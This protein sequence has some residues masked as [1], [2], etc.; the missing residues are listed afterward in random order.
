MMNYVLITG[1]S[2]G[3]GTIVVN[4]FLCAGLK[5]IIFDLDENSSRKIV[6]ANQE[7]LLFFKVNMSNADEI[8]EISKKLAH[9][10]IRI[11]H[12]ISLA[13]GALIEEF[14]GLEKLDS[15]LI[16]KSIK[17]NL[18]SHIILSK[19]ILPLMKNCD[20]PNKSITFI[21]SINALM[22]FGLPAYSAAKSGLLGITKVLSSEVGKYNIRVNSVL[23]GTTIT[24]RTSSEPKTYDEYLKGS[25]LSRFATADEIAEVIY[26][27]SEKLTC[28][29]GQHIIAD[30]G[31]TVKGYY[32]NH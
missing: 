15:D 7:S 28:I 6:E 21:S 9:I 24:K 1:G 20:L 23:P 25:L 22:D 16:E 2:G 13:G 3:I 31:Q 18:S 19:N 30:C 26:C 4:R 11:Q 29:T 12:C 14:G 5:V 10:G 17:L 32:E 27:I 8:I